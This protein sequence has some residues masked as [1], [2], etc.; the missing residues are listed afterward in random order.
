MEHVSIDERDDGVV[1]LAVDRPPVNAMDV[2][3]L[4]EVVAAVAQVAGEAPRA[5]VLAGRPGCFS[6]GADLKAVP[7]YGPA[8]QREMVAGINA[9]ALGVYELQF[10]V[11]GAITGH[12]IAGGM[13]LALCTDIRVASVAGRYGL[14]E[15]QVGV[16]YPQAAIGVVRAELSPQAARLLALGSELTDARECER[17]G[18][19][20]EVL[21]AEDVLSRSLHLAQ[22]LAKLPPEVYA[23]TKRDLRAPALAWMRAA[24]EEDPL[25]AAWVQ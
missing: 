24:V 6:A 10:P 7:G 18:V 16:P 17:L 1:L 2:T 13:V 21:D 22:R 5:L 15:V 23:R 4:R 25:L 8:E 12:A 19:F 20:D 14:T 11:V 9:M 3:L